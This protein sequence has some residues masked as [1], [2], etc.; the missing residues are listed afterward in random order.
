M[1]SLILKFNSFI[2]M[3]VLG[4]DRDAAGMRQG[5]DGDATGKLQAC[6]RDTTAMRQGGP[7]WLSAFLSHYLT[8]CLPVSM[9]HC[10]AGCLARFLAAL[11]LGLLAPSL[12]NFLAS[13]LPVWSLGSE[14]LSLGCCWVCGCC[15]CCLLLRL[16]ASFA[17][18]PGLTDSQACWLAAG[19]GCG[20]GC[21][22]GCAVAAAV[23]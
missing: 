1:N 2:T 17:G 10:P 7:S 5:G 3:Y 18:S 19:F 6:D 20:F 21:S 9:D 12:A 11:L 15:I 23:A 16:R 14:F 13:S 8:G 22:C 4:C